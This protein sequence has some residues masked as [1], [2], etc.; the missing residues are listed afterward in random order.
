[1]TGGFSLWD[2]VSGQLL[3]HCGDGRDAPRVFAF[4]PDG[5][6]LALG[7]ID[8]VVRLWD[9]YTGQEIRRFHGHQEIIWS[10]AF[11]PDGRTLA[12]GSGDGI[13]LLWDLTSWPKETGLGRPAKL[14]ALWDDLGGGDAARADRAFWALVAAPR[15]ALPLLRDRLMPAQPADGKLAGLIADLDSRH[16]TVREKATQQL[17]KLGDAAAPALRRALAGKPSAEAR[18]R[19]EALLASLDQS[20][21]PLS[22]A[23][24][25]E[26]R[27]VRV[28]GQVGSAEARTLL[29]KL[30]ALVEKPG[31]A[32]EASAALERAARRK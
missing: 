5:R 17:E 14:D 10:L 8:R 12:S 30:A 32:A 23:A 1:L 3:G 26:R 31:L 18:R 27:A 22:A 28:L 11:S 19:L 29:E 15:S 4:A 7:G 21:R 9:A 25:R 2:T 24:V 20:S 16:F 13:G 6:T